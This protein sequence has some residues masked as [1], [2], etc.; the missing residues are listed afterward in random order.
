MI[1]VILNSKSTGILEM[2]GMSIP[3]IQVG[4][5]ILCTV[6]ILA[7][8]ERC[9]TMKQTPQTLWRKVLTNRTDNNEELQVVLE[10]HK[11]TFRFKLF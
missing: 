4:F 11:L 9:N 7:D 1:P 5:T 6:L 10:L 3:S 2:P 8:L